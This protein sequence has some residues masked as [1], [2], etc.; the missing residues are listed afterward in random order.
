M[1]TLK[2]LCFFT[3]T[4]A[5]YFLLKPVMELC[6]LDPE[7]ELQL[8]VSGTHLDEAFG[9]TINDIES[10]S[11]P[12]SARIPIL[13]KEDGQVAACEATGAALAGVGK[14]LHNLA[15]DAL[16]LLGDRY[17][18]LAAA[19]AAVLCRI[20][21]AHLHGGEVT[22][23]AVDDLFR[24]AV[25]KMS[26][27]H[28]TSSE[29][30]RNRVINMGEH[31]N[32][33]F[34]V[35]AIGVE[36]A[37]TTAPPAPDELVNRIGFM[38]DKHTLLLTVHPETASEFPLAP[39][40]A[41]LSALNNMPGTPLI[42]T[43]SNADPDGRASNAILT[44]FISGRSASAVLVDS[45]GQSCYLDT[46]KRCGAVVGN[47]SSGI[48]EIPG[49]GTPTVNIGR[50]QEGRPQAQSVI[51]VQS[52]SEEILQA[53]ERALSVEFQAI[54]VQAK[55][56]FYKPGTAQNIMRHLKAISIDDETKL[57]KPSGTT[58]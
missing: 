37:H 52:S 7:V 27:L 49:T 29:E 3:A 53:I 36:T 34:N 26:T 38:P 55:N 51:D 18:T 39:L 50:R 43:K 32:N 13:S 54:S 47:S 5:E 17:E 15:P 1:T 19:G 31:E 25:T 14:A 16:V 8:L 57:S 30:H 48:I 45:L 46:A 12:I 11:F 6:M 20:P 24:N 2:S 58:S 9:S 35:G 44:E 41:L 10:D 56:L 22:L 28:F 23:G 42:F 40:Q 4:R 33:V 21:I